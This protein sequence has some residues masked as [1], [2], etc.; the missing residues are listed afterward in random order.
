MHRFIYRARWFA[1][2]AFFA[3]GCNGQ[4][5]ELLAPVLAEQV[6]PLTPVRAGMNYGHLTWRPVG[7]R[8]A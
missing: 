7:P 2:L 3:V 6:S 5:G 8:T 4:E 1:L